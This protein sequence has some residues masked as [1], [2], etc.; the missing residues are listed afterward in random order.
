MRFLF[1]CHLMMFFWWCFGGQGSCC[2]CSCPSCWI[3][4]WNKHC[5]LCS[6]LQD[7]FT[8]EHIKNKQHKLFQLFCQ[9]DCFIQ[10]YGLLQYFLL[11]R[12]FFG[13]ASL[14]VNVCKSACDF[15]SIWADFAHNSQMVWMACKPLICGPGWM[16]G[17]QIL[18]LTGAYSLRVLPLTL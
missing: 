13:E 12:W 17:G 14:P 11:G 10:T 15:A 8:G 3:P 1:V 5:W 4:C 16:A 6:L 9:G 7:W 2:L 18:Q